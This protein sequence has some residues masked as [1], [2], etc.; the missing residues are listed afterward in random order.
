MNPT[1]E[2]KCANPS[3][4]MTLSDPRPAD[5]VT[6]APRLGDILLCGGCG[7]P[8]K[9]TIVGTKLLTEEDFTGLSPDERR[10]LDF[11]QRAIKR[12]IRNS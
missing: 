4:G 11:A 10:D 9:V 8:S 2:H 1:V 7:H 5:L 12:K 3:C 6:E